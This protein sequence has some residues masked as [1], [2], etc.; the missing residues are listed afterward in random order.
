MVLTDICPMFCRHC[1]RKRE[2]RHGGWVRP[3]SEIEAMLEY[4]DVYLQ[5]L[6]KDN[7]KMKFAVARAL[8]LIDI[9]KI[10]REAQFKDEK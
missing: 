8:E 4:L 2:W 7:S 1:T 9:E 3:A 6:A 5:A 10:Y